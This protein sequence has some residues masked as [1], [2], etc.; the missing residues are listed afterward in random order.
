MVLLCPVLEL[1]MSAVEKRKAAVR[2]KDKGNEVSCSLLN[3]QNLQALALC[4]LHR[5]FE[6]V[7]MR[8]HSLTTPAASYWTTLP[9]HTTTG[10]SHSSSYSDTRKPCKTARRCSNWSPPTPRVIRGIVYL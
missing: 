8:K 9:L 2:E 4:Y 5:H 7:T 1:S 6:L 3:Q 10:P